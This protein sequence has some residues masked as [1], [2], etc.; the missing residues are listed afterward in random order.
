LCNSPELIAN[1]KENINIFQLFQ[2]R[3]LPNFAPMN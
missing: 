1:A 2:S 3:T